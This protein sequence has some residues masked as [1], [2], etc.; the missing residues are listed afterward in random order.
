M[1]FDDYFSFPR[2]LDM[3]PYTT[4]GIAAKEDRDSLQEL[5]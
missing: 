1:K 3:G 5:F 4:E 2:V